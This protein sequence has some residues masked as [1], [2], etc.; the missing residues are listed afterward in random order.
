VLLNNNDRLEGS[1]ESWQQTFATITTLL[2]I[3]IARE[4][5]EKKRSKR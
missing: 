1:G 3:D 4:G 2:M 5:K